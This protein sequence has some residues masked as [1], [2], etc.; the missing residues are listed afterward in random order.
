ME[1]LTE[2]QRVLVQAAVNAVAIQLSAHATPQERLN[3]GEVR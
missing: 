1:N 3:A 2:D